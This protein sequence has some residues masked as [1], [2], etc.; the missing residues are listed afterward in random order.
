MVRQEVLERSMAEG[1]YISFDDVL[2]KPGYSELAPTEPDV[3][4]RLSRSIRLKMPVVSAAMDTVTEERMAKEMAL[5]GAIG[6]LHRNLTAERQAEMVRSVRRSGNIVF[7]P[8]VVEEDMAVDEI[9][10]KATRLGFQTF[11]V[12]RKERLVG[13]VTGRGLRLA[14][15]SG[16]GR[17]AGDIME[18]DLVTVPPGTPMEEALDRMHSHRVKK[19][20]VVEGEKLVGL[21]TLKDY[22]KRLRF[23]D[24]TR[25]EEG[26]LKV[27]AA[28]GILPNDRKR[29]ELLCRAGV[30]ALVVDSSHGHSSAVIKTVK[31][32]K[33]EFDIEV[34]AG[35]VTDGDGAVALAEAGADGIKVGIGPGSACTTRQV[36]GAGMPQLS[37][38]Y[39]ARK[40][41]EKE[42][43]EVPVI[44]D[45]GIKGSGDIVKA[46]VAGADSVMVG[47]LLAATDAAP[48]EEVI[49][50]GRKYKSYRG[51]ASPSALGSRAGYGRAPEGVEGL[52]PYAGR[53]HE[54]LALLKG[55]M[56][57]GFAHVGAGNLKELREKAV[58]IRASSIKE[59]QSL[60]VVMDRKPSKGYNV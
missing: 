30:N 19:L 29:V 38:V 51:M 4:G 24:A 33:R 3:S 41:L 59:G 14:K 55:G 12:V 17:T 32:L 13:L 56:K 42:G 53:V 34:V 36:T 7:D 50:G 27:A 31:V 28:V 35:N 25:D 11:P 39:L 60:P 47:S 2:V 46:M 8:V 40:G 5:F 57:S 22:E 26:R 44:A 58:L 49:Y 54:V 18:K 9:Y 23:P 52:V 15:L 1:E 21:I 10:E 43:L 6:V 37:A 48:G 20:L 16:R 45:G